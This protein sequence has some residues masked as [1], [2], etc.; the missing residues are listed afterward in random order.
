L[1]SLGVL[2]LVAH[3]DLAAGAQQLADVALEGVV[4][5]A[6]HRRLGGGPFLPRGELD[7]EDRRRA[8]GVLEEQLVEVAHPV[9]EDGVPGAAP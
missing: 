8:L 5:H 6:A 3:G 2:D 7:L 1:A 9:E 4:R